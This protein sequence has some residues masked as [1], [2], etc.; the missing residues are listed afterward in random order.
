MKHNLQKQ[1]FTMLILI[2]CAATISK[3]WK[4]HEKFL[5]VG[6][7]H[8]IGLA[9]LGGAFTS[10]GSFH[11]DSKFHPTSVGWNLESTW[12]LPSLR[13]RTDLLRSWT[14]HSGASRTWS[15]WCC[16]SDY[17]TNP[18]CR[19]V[20]RCPWIPGLSS[21]WWASQSLNWDILTWNCYCW[22]VNLQYVLELR[23]LSCSIS[24]CH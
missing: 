15:W 5:S 24:W 8:R 13:L 23:R 6:V 18:S 9:G 4:Q 19:L 14:C 20:G 1:E 7:R 16:V 17:L 12:K 21:S 22:I 10:T 11:V 3:I 2:L